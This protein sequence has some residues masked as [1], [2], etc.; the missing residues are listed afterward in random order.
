MSDPKSFPT[1]FTMSD[2]KLVG[3]LLNVSH[4][5]GGSKA[6]FLLAFG[7]SPDRPE[8]LAD[9]LGRHVATQAPRQP[10]S[11]GGPRKL[12]YEGPI[13]APD[14]REPSVRSI[15]QIEADGTA[16]LVSVVP[17]RKRR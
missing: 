12:I 16:R 17:L 14:G 9:A 8:E 6:R 11:E 3:Y 5:R 2:G 4:P 7:F 10:R 15:W 1:R 13:R